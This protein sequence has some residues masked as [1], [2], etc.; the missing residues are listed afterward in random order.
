MVKAF[1]RRFFCALKIQLLLL[2]ATS[3]VAHKAEARHVAGYSPGKVGFSVKFKDIVSTYQIISAYVLPGETLAIKAESPEDTDTYSLETAAG[4]LIKT[5]S[6]YWE[7]R[8][9]KKVGFYPLTV[10]QL[11]SGEAMTI[12]VFV[13]VPLNRLRRGYVNG[14]RVG[15]YPSVPLRLLPNYRT[16][17]GFIEVTSENE[18][19]LVSPHFTLKQFV[20]KQEANYPKYIVLKENLLVK[21]ELLL[22]KANEKGYSCDTFEVMSGY[23]TP[24]YNRLIGNVRYSF[25]LWGGAADIFID[26]NPQ[27]GVIDDLNQDGRVDRADAE[28][29]CNLVEEICPE[30]IQAS[31]LGGLGIYRASTSHGP[32]IHLDVRGKVARWMD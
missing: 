11:Q 29:L 22:E 17:K 5:A 23:R 2:L 7:W 12:N 30:P 9:P 6:S 13:M 10:T 24:Y 26:Q 20:C 25:H 3:L 27:D 15:R 8:A 32:F 28:V 14:Y 19:V 31:F 4:V 1:I 16:P 21:L 18:D